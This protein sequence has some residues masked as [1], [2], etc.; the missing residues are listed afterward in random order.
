VVPPRTRRC[1]IGLRDRHEYKLRSLEEAREK[2]ATEFL[3]DR[4]PETGDCERQPRLRGLEQLGGPFEFAVTHYYLV[5]T[6]RRVFMV[7]L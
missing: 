3:C 6:D 2:R 1:R 4:R 7:Q 5:L